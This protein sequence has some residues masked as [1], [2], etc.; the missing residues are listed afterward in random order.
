MEMVKARMEKKIVRRISSRRRKSPEIRE[1]H[2]THKS[3]PFT[4]RFLKAFH[5]E[6]TERFRQD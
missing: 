6:F 3:I 1:F 5:T 4:S 2:P